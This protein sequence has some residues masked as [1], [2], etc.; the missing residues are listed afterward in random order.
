MTQL[1]YFFSFSS[2]GA[3]A[4][5]LGAGAGFDFGALASC[6]GAGWLSALGALAFGVLSL[7]ALS[8]GALS[9]GALSLG[10]LAFGALSLGELSAWGAGFDSLGRLA[11]AFGR[12]VVSGRLALGG[13]SLFAGRF[14][15][16]GRSAF[17]RLI[18]SDRLLGALLLLLGGVNGLL[19]G[20]APPA[21]F[22]AGVLARFSAGPE[23]RASLGDIAGA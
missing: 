15:V 23:A 6:D 20:F 21:R 8:F 16:E 18:F 10:A 9:L 17:S 14:A 22:S 2:F 1:A 19:A 4:A 7:G 12:F 11:S 3:G 13:R 5:F